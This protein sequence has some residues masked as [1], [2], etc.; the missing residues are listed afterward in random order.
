M[1]EK[2]KKKKKNSNIGFSTQS[3]VWFESYLFNSSIQVKSK[4][5]SPML[6]SSTTECHKD[7]LYSLYCLFFLLYLDD[8]FQTVDCDLFLYA[9]DSC[10]V[11][12]H[13]D[14]K[15]IEQQLNKNFFEGLWLV[16]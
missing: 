13:R 14:V 10:L 6:L 7:L 4:E 3:S 5:N 11:Y 15:E 8:M 12:Q 2:K 1:P 16:F 9:N